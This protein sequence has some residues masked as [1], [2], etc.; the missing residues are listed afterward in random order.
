MFTP[1][2][3]YVPF[4]G[5]PPL[6]AE[7]MARWTLDPALL[8]G[9]ALALALGLWR[10]PAGGG[11]RASFIS[12]WGLTAI[13]FVSPIC[14]LSMALFS[15]RVGQHLLLTLVAAPLIAHALDGRRVP[16][17]GGAIVFSGFFWFWH[18][19]TPYQTTLQ[20]DAIY[21]AMHLTLLGSAIVF[22]SALFGRMDRQPI[23]GFLSAILVGAQMSALSAILVFSTGLWHDWHRAVTA[24]YGLSAMADQAL[25]GGLMWVF[26]SLLFVGAIGLMVVR[27][28]ARAE[29]RAGIGHATSPR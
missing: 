27:L 8:A 5:M 24:P 29:S 18:L 7:L 23:S 9:L 13:A 26:G 10:V 2:P 19:P 28:V 14:A 6:P 1:D 15:A 12:G 21:W 17:M 22:W 25:A 3:D 20:S 11:A 4:C 16:P